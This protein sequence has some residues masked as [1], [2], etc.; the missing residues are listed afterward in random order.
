MITKAYVALLVITALLVVLFLSFGIGGFFYIRNLV[1]DGILDH[2]LVRENTEGADYF[3]KNYGKDRGSTY[4][5]YHMWNLT[6]QDEVMLGGTPH[7]EEIGPYAYQQKR[8]RIDA[9]WYDGGDRVEFTEFSEYI[10]VPEMSGA[11]LSEDD[12]IVNL[13]QVYAGG[14]LLASGN[15]QNLLSLLSGGFLEV[16]LS[17]YFL[18]ESYVRSAISSYRGKVLSSA[19]EEIRSYYPNPSDEGHIL[20]LLGNSTLASDCGKY[21]SNN[22]CISLFDGLTTGAGLSV[23]QTQK[24]IDGSGSYAIYN[25]KSSTSQEAWSKY[26]YEQDMTSFSEL[27]SYMEADQTT[28]D[29][30]CGWLIMVDETRVSDFIV[31][32]YGIEHVSEIGYVEWGT[33]IVSNATKKNVN[34]KAIG[35][36]DVTLSYGEMMRELSMDPS[37]F[38]ISVET[39]KKI[40]SHDG[41]FYDRDTWMGFLVGFMTMGPSV[42]EQFG[43][44]EQ[45]TMLFM[46][47]YVQGMMVPYAVPTLMG[48]DKTSG[49]FVHRDVRGWLFDCYDSTA[50]AACNLFTSQTESQAR[51]VDHRSSAF[52]GKGTSKDS[53]LYEA[54]NGTD[55]LHV[56]AEPVAVGGTDGT[57]FR[58]FLQSVEWKPKKADGY[59][60]LT[61]F[62]PELTRM[63]DLQHVESVTFKDIDL[64]RYRIAPDMLEISELYFTRIRGVLNMTTV[65]GSTIMMSK[66][67]FLDCDTSAYENITGMSPNRELHDTFVDVEPHLGSMF[68]GHKRL[69]LSV[70]LP[71]WWSLSLESHSESPRILY[72]VVWFDLC[73]EASDHETD[74]FKDKILRGL[75]FMKILPIACG[76]LFFFSAVGFGLTL[77][78]YCK[79]KGRKGYVEV[80]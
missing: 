22:T 38:A 60:T 41:G 63:I 35:G 36:V 15:E 59:E 29:S 21:F 51:A 61:A 66:P 67:H 46:L 80:I 69:Q 13:N 73:G 75:L 74:E 12:V 64:W 5:I 24:L 65:F 8:R 40:F 42:G 52:T 9:E 44:T 27:S 33:G 25:E 7:F 56:W 47:Y 6:N 34:M 23:S 53:A 76:V 4:S 45:Q 70:A 55:T 58:P 11:G 26:C 30:L 32:N 71:D 19:L 50:G 31:W 43:L 79:A 49:L 39:C 18:S 1:V 17:N 68:R 37:L 57:R 54:Y 28:I 20:D 77:W 10:F 3:E 62:V 78:R 72:P 48:M 16:V 2:S 14:L